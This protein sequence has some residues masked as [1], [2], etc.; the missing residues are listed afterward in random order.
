MKKL[1]ILLLGLVS[2]SEPWI[3]EFVEQH[4][5]QTYEQESDYVYY[6]AVY[7]NDRIIDN[8]DVLWYTPELYN[9]TID[10]TDN[11]I[12]KYSAHSKEYIPEPVIT[13]KIRTIEWQMH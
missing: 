4:S 11:S 12:I 8:V 1:L 9:V 3:E 5:F 7:F 2:C 13:L 10:K 6:G